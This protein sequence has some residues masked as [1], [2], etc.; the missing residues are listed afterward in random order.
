[1]PQLS[2]YVT[3]ENLELLRSR[4]QEA[5]VSMSK[6]VNNL[7]RSDSENSGWPNG[8]WE[9]YG[10]IDDDSFCPPEDAPPLDDHK[11]ASMLG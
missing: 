4:A 2:L 1:M 8:F 7:I 11:F 3:D 10:A 5:G 6:H 9:L